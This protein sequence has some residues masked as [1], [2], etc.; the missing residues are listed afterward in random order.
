MENSHS[1]KGQIFRKLGLVFVG[2]IVGYV[3]AFALMEWE[4]SRKKLTDSVELVLRE[5]DHEKVSLLI[6][7]ITASDSVDGGRNVISSNMIEDGEKTLVLV[8]LPA[9]Y[10]TEKVS[11]SV[12]YRLSQH[13][14]L[15]KV[16]SI[17]FRF[18]EN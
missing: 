1:K 9:N 15:G 11:K 8:S 13:D 6:S 7:S 10:D 3:L 12:I 5:P 17:K 4:Q 16:E 2:I 18:A 14:M